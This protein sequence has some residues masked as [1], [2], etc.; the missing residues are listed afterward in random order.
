MWAWTGGEASAGA[1]ALDQAVDR[2]RHERAAAF[3][4]EHKGAV[5]KLPA[6]LAQRSHL[7]AAER[8]G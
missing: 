2:I 4:G 6:Q 3:G 5:G 8:R 1:D 7:V